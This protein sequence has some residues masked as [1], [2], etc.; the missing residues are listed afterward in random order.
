M[1]G[2]AWPLPSGKSHP[3]HSPSYQT[4]LFLGSYSMLTFDTASPSTGL[5]AGSCLYWA[6]FVLHPTK[7]TNFLWVHL[8]VFKSASTFAF[9]FTCGFLQSQGS[10]LQLLIILVPPKQRPPDI[11][12]LHI[13]TLPTVMP[14]L[15]LTIRRLI[16]ILRNMIV[17]LLLN[18]LHSVLSVSVC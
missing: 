9:D 2:L 3:A 1:K 12:S 10:R 13:C 8:W 11:R 18:V 7:N 16:K 15:N 5:H 14:F 6:F 4:S 17:N